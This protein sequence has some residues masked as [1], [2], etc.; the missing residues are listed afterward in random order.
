M[1]GQHATAAERRVEPPVDR[2]RI[3][4]R[5][6]LRPKRLPRDARDLPD[7]A[8]LHELDAA[9]DDRRVMPV[10]H[11]VDDAASLLGK[12]GHPRQ[13]IGRDD[14]RLL[15]EHVEAALQRATHQ[16]AVARGRCADIDEVERLVR[17][18]VFDR[19]VPARRRQPRLGGLSTRGLGVTEGDDLDIVAAGPARQV[20]FD[21]D[22]AQADDRPA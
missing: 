12:P 8:L 1:I 11:R 10:V 19:V 15:A 17:E 14:E 20:A 16:E 3:A 4:G 21:G 18:K 9:L 2:V 13:V 5:G 22:V 7:R 6:G